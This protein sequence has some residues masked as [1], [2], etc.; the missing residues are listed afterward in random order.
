MIIDKISKICYYEINTILGQQNAT[1][2]N[3]YSHAVFF[4]KA[5]KQYFYFVRCV[6]LRVL[7]ELTATLLQHFVG[8]NAAFALTNT[9]VAL[10]I[11]PM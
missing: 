4:C 9:Y 7:R 6:Y 2:C 10:V 5:Q 3:F 11:I 1:K 8:I